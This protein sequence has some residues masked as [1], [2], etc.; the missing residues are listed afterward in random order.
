MSTVHYDHCTISSSLLHINNKAAAM[1][2]N[3]HTRARAFSAN[4]PER[5]HIHGYDD[6][7]DDDVTT[8]HNYTRLF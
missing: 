3:V 4:A 1:R 2:T 6:F 5:I 8:I 7:D